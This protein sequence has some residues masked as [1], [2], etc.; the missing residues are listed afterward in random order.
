MGFS[1]SASLLVIFI[2]LLIG[3]GSIYTAA[4]NSGEHLTDAQQD[5]L[6]RFT[7]V[8][9]TDITLTSAVWHTTDENL[10]IRINNTGS[11]ELSVET[12]DALV[13]GA[14]TQASDFPIATVGGHDTDLW[15]LAEQLRLERTETETPERVKIVT[16]VGV[17]DTQAVRPAG[18]AFT[19]NGFSADNTGDGTNEAVGFDIE[20]SYEDNVTLTDVTIES[21]DTTA[22]YIDYQDAGDPAE[23]EIALGS[24]LSQPV[25]T[26]TGNFSV[27][28]T[29]TTDSTVELTPDGL[30]QYTVGEF[31][32][33]GSSQAVDMQ[34][35]EVTV[36][37]DYEDP[38]G[39]ARTLTFTKVVDN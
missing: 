36:S 17:A 7:A 22:D 19:G 29:I 31:R 5:Q 39:V 20:S 4:S 14:Y 16:E 38:Y 24:D 11:T 26:A 30:A 33:S 23:V 34:G 25:A 32:V 27:G 12:T 18:I 37:V 10:T 3:L 9:G 8:E 6:D 2:G 21:T 35:A 15:G 1:T 13:D 28:E